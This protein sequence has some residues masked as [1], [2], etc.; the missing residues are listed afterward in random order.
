MNFM[1]PL[2]RRNVKVSILPASARE[3][4]CR[5]AGSLARQDRNPLNLTAH[6]TLLWDLINFPRRD[7]RNY[8]RP[9]TGITIIV[10]NSPTLRLLPGSLNTGLEFGQQPFQPSPSPLG[11]LQSLRG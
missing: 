3:S 4:R 10:V 2:Q 7:G 5:W 9:V 8:R 1:F 11:E 6:G